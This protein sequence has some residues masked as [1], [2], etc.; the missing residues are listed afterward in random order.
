MDRF[1]AMRTF[2]AIAGEGSLSAA[3]RKLGQPLTSVSRQLAALEAHLGATLVNRTTRRF[4]LTDAGGA[5]A[6]SAGGCW[7]SFRR[8]KARWAGAAATSAA[9]S[10]SRRR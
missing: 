4:A 9:R 7:T 5:M 8:R 6:R 3:A 1:R 2:L 10:C